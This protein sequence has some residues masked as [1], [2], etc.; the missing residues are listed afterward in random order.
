MGDKGLFDA[1][2]CGKTVRAHTMSKLR[3]ENVA[4]HTWGVL[5]L[6]IRYLPGCSAEFLAYL[7]VHDMGERGAADIPAPVLWGNPALA[8]AVQHVEDQHVQAVMQGARPWCNPRYL[9]SEDE[10]LCAE[11]LDRAEFLLSC[12]YERRMG[13]TL[14]EEAVARAYARITE[15]AAKIL[16]EELSDAMFRLVA[17]LEQIT[18][19]TK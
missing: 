18:G 1:W 6:A 7:I 5:M 10:L 19:E 17:D 3:H 15:V 12:V 14:A 13:N 8:K 16:P 4:E 2:L 9:L 11:I